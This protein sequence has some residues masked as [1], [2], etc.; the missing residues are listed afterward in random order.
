MK[1]LHESL[2]GGSTCYV[3]LEASDAYGAMQNARGK[4]EMVHKSR[5]QSGGD[6]NACGVIER[7]MVSALR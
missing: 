1:C 3:D 5:A 6:R 2:P 7:K 4:A